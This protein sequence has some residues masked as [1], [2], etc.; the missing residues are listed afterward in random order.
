VRQ[1]SIASA[2]TVELQTIHVNATVIANAKSAMLIF[3]YGVQSWSQFFG[4]KVTAGFCQF[5]A[6][7][8]DAWSKFGCN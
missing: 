2:A 7:R 3:D 8:L 1:N 4:K 5:P 6:V